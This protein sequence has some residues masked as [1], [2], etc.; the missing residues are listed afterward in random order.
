MNTLYQALLATEAITRP[1]EVQVHTIYLIAGWV[2]DIVNQRKSPVAQTATLTEWSAYFQQRSK[3]VIVMNPLNQNMQ[4][5]LGPVTHQDVG[6][7][8]PTPLPTPGPT[9]KEGRAPVPEDAWYAGGSCHSQP[10][11]W[12]AKAYQPSTDSIWMEDGSG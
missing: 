5:L 4:Q 10:P 3:L 7:E 8:V 12:R 6:M 9:I 2:Q 1:A 11:S